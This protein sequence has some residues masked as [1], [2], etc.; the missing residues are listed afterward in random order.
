MSVLERIVETRIVAI[1]RGDYQ[2]R[3]L[4][5]AQALIDGGIPVMEVTLNSPG[6]VDGIALLRARL[7]ERIVLGAGT[8]LTTD[9]VRRAADAGASF[10]V[11]PDTDESVIEACKSLGLPVIPGAYTPTEIKRAYALGAD[12]VKLFPA[13]TPDYI[14]AI[15]GPL[16]HI[17]LMATGGVELGNAAE[18][19]KA[20]VK[21]IGLGSSLTKPTFTADD[22]RARA[23]QF[24]AAAHGRQIA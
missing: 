16:N 20:G 19:F 7:G 22:I 13:Q 17:P 15:R 12:M 23:A 14:K 5:V 1:F 2:G 24:V 11:A 4:E 18:F 6:A 8:V 9:E 3:W 21:A 10:V